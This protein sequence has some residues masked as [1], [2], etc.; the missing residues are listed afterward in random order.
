MDRGQAN[1]YR[2][3]RR[4]LAA[5]LLAALV[6]LAS[7]AAAQASTI[8]VNTTGDPSGSG[9]CLDSGQCSLRQAV[10]A[11]S[12]GDTIQLPAGNYSLTLG[13]DIDI[14]KSLTIEGDTTS[15]TTIDGSQNTARIL[16]IDDASVT[17]ENLTLTGGD[18]GA[19]EFPC[20]NPCYTYELNGGG[21]LWNNG[22]TVNS[23]TSPSQTIPAVPLPASSRT[24]GGT[25]TMT[26]VSFT[27]DK[28]A[29]VAPYSPTA[30]RSS[31]TMSR[32][33]TTQPACCNDGAIYLLGG[34]VSLTN[35]TV[36]GNG[37]SAS[38]GGGIHNGGA[39][40]T[41]TNDTLSGNVRG[42]LM[43]D[44]EPAS[45]TVENTII[46]AGFTEGGDCACVAPGQAG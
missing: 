20:G 24:T 28:L 15:D 22:G 33:R 29:S 9:A 31:G 16:R 25:L 13:T 46:A 40:L 14:A 37:G 36:V 35:T 42:S 3:L 38:I 23:P 2:R 10:A 34:T 27:D 7:A 45:T 21:A 41:L 1:G 44:P 5:P 39:R 19:D 43:T 18:D 26:D 32:S 12:S 11:A 4:A 6:L 30:A 8:V 17:I